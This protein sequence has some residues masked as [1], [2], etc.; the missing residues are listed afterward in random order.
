MMEN[1][2]VMK[3][4]LSHG[5]TCSVGGTDPITGECKCPQCRSI[6]SLLSLHARH[7]PCILS[8]RCPVAQCDALRIQI[9]EKGCERDPL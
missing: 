7:C 6:W 9:F 4:F 1:C 5:I 8:E 3:R 2:K